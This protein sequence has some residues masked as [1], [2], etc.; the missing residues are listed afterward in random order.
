MHSVLES[1]KMWS[2]STGLPGKSPVRCTH[3]QLVFLLPNSEPSQ[4][5]VFRVRRGFPLPD[6]VGPAIVEPLIAH[7]AFFCEAAGN[8]VPVFRR[9][10]GGIS[11]LIGPF[12]YQRSRHK[13]IRGSPAYRLLTHGNYAHAHETRSPDKSFRGKLIP[14]KKKVGLRLHPGRPK[15]YT[16]LGSISAPDDGA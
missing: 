1:V 14:H 5:V 2:R 4:N 15:S 11:A 13:V 3:R 12:A 7:Y 9:F 16:H 10:G 8:R 6:R